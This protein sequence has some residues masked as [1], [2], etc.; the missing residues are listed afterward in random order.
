M[1]DRPRRIRHSR[2]D[3]RKGCSRT[4]GRSY[5]VSMIQEK[6]NLDGYAGL[7]CAV[8]LVIDDDALI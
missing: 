7:I 6:D 2:N 4:E 8:L 5:F 1:I 3:Y